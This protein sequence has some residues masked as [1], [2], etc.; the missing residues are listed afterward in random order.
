M[1]YCATEIDTLEV[2][3]VPYWCILFWVKLVFL[4]W[5]KLVFFLMAA[6]LSF[7]NDDLRAEF[8]QSAECLSLMEKITTIHSIW[9]Y[10]PLWQKLEPLWKKCSSPFLW[11]CFE[12]WQ[13]PFKLPFTL[14]GKTNFALSQC[15]R[16]LG[17][18]L[19]WWAALSETWMLVL[20]PQAYTQETHCLEVGRG[21]GFD[22]MSVTQ[23]TKLEQS[24]EVQDTFQSQRVPTGHI[25]QFN[26]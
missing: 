17:E 4:S 1:Y 5:V 15:V 9:P 10:T 2:S 6:V 3:K 19:A 24:L 16:I 13:I 8:Q 14:C 26:I 25:C 23:G 7:D 11:P 12:R 22:T 20:A 21:P 18:E